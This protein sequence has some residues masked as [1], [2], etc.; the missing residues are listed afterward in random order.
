MNALPQVG[1]RATR[2]AASGAGSSAESPV[3]TRTMI[4]EVPGDGFAAG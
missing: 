1:Q 2:A 3:G 4:P